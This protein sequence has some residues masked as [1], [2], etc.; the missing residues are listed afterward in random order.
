MSS[1]SHPST[2]PSKKQ[3]Q[4]APEP[5][6]AP[7]AHG[8]APPAPIVP[9]AATKAPALKV[10]APKPIPPKMPEPMPM[11]PKVPEPKPMMPPLSSTTVAMPQSI[12]AIIR[13]MDSIEPG[14]QYF[15]RQADTRNGCSKTRKKLRAFADKHPSHPAVSFWVATDKWEPP[16]EFALAEIVKLL[17]TMIK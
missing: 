3:R 1:S 17:K 12:D 11:L 16:S 4:V 5:Q 7:P 2:P 13:Y 10:P 15:E 6:S 14:A 9:Q 8:T